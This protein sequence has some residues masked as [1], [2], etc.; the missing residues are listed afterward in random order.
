MKASRI[1]AVDFFE[2]LSSPFARKR[3]F[4]G[5]ILACV[6]CIGALYLVDFLP[7]GWGRQTANEIA[8]HLLADFLVIIAFYFLYMY[9]IGPNEGLGAIRVTRPRDIRGQLQTLTA[10]TS[11]YMFWGRSGAYFR[12]NPLVARS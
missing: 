4:W 11:S 9:F 6:L 1:T 3:F 10:E 12:S 7:S 8:V 2:D 5:F